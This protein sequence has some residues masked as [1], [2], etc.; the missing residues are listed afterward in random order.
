M[1]LVAVG[2]SVIPALAG[3]MVANIQL[4]EAKVAFTRLH[5]ISSL[6]KEYETSNN[7]IRSSKSKP[8]KNNFHSLNLQKM[9]FRF[10]GR[11][12]VLKEVT[13][14]VKSGEIVSVFG[15]VGSGKSTL[16]DLLQ[17]F[18]KLETGSMHLNEKSIDD[19]GLSA[20]RSKIAVVAQTEKIF[21]STVL[22]NICISNDPNEMNR[23]AEFMHAIGMDTFF[24][25]LPQGYLTLCGEEGRSLSGGQKQLISI[26]RALY[27]QP[28]FLVLD[29]STS[30]MDFDT[31]SEILEI[32]KR[33]S[34]SFC[35]GIILITHRIGLAKQT[36]R[37][38]IL[39]SGTISDSGTHEELATGK[40]D[41]A[42]AFQLLTEINSLN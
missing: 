1:A 26:A 21:N 7:E 35:V 15:Q 41:Y 30:A 17:G 22:D 5:E 6:Q 42:R 27:K 14:Q 25:Q 36:D 11:T 34:G 13:F 40:N 28:A 38:L 32:L 16:V 4:Q 23:C 31:E 9:S 39:N 19:W 20:W 33:Y 18:H 3:L 10:P 37:I 12:Q 2:G 8:T 29:E 24:N